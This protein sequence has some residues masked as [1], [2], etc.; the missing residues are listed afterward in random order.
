MAPLQALEALEGACCQE[1]SPGYGPSYLYFARD[2]HLI[3]NGHWALHLRNAETAP[4]LPKRPHLH[5]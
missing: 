4:E 3:G 1:I 5:V 2:R